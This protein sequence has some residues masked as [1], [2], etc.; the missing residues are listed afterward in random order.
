MSALMTRSP[1]GESG[2]RDGRRRGCERGGLGPTMPPTPPSA[3]TGS[4]P[5]DDLLNDG[6]LGVGVVLDVRPPSGGK[7]TLGALIELTLFGVVAQHIAEE[8]HP[9]RFCSPDAEDV[10]LHVRVEIS[11]EPMLV[12]FGLPKLE[13]VPGG[14]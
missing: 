14:L 11:K 3:S 8:Q 6:G 9:L 7:L 10:H 4:S 2:N 12:P 5:E 1:Q 13:L